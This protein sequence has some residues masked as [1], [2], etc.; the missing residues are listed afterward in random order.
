MFGK[1][2]LKELS[3][4]LENLS[5]EISLGVGMEI[6]MKISIEISMRLTFT[7]GNQH[8]NKHGFKQSSS[9]SICLKTALKFQHGGTFPYA[10]VIRRAGATFSCTFSTAG[11]G[12][13]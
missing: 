10:H 12:C 3:T 8:G 1:P 13:T 9:L 7:H 5:M 2:A 6:S 4:G 11:R